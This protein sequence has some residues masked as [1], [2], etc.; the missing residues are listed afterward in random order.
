MLV[1]EP[2]ALANLLTSVQ[3]QINLLI[4]NSTAHNRINFTNSGSSASGGL[5]YGSGNTMEFRTDDTEQMRID[6][7]GRLNIGATS[8]GF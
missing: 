6:S 1:L 8:N 2:P 7:A 3:D 5:W 4:Y